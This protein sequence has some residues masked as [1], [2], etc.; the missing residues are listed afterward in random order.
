M[1]PYKIQKN[2]FYNLMIVILKQK[3]IFNVNLII[4][5]NNGN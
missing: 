1:K 3:N 4:K 2:V 5:K